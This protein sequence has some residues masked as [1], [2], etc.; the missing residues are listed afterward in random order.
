M[1]RKTLI[2]VLILILAIAGIGF[3]LIKPGFSEM[4]GLTMKISEA[5]DELVRKE[6][7][8]ARVENLKEKYQQAEEKIEK[9]YQVLPLEPDI[10]GILV[11][12]ETLASENG[13]LL[14]KII[15][16]LPK[17]AVKVFRPQVGANQGKK[18]VLPFKT[19]IVVLEVSGSYQSFKNFLEAL[20]NSLRLMDISGITLSAKEKEGAVSYSYNLTFNTYYQ[21]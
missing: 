15:Y 9:I 2:I 14:E 8:L 7:L 6:S 12:T 19:M 16:T 20:E 5:R 4:K 1:T 10:P 18:Q 3:W 21:E 13:L 17:E 11:Q